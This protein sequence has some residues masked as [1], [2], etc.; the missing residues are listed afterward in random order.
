MASGVRLH[1]WGAMSTTCQDK[2]TVTEESGGVGCKGTW[3]SPSSILLFGIPYQPPV[4]LRGQGQL[5]G[6]WM[7]RI[8]RTSWGTDELGRR[9]KGMVGEESTIHLGPLLGQLANPLP[10]T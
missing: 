2:G 8:T 9:V 6:S 3:G 7:P 4:T 1:Q 5:L 10:E